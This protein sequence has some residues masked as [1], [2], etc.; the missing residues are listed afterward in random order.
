MTRFIELAKLALGG[1]RRAP[2]RTSLTVFGVAVSTGA[3]VTMVGYAFGMQRRFEAVFDALDLAKRIGVSPRQLSLIEAKRGDAH[4]EARPPLLDDEAVR[5]IST[6]RGVDRVYPQF[7]MHVEVSHGDVDTSVFALGMPNGSPGTALL[8]R[9]IVAGD[10]FA[11]EGPPGGL[12]SSSV[13]PEL[14]ISDPAAAIGATVTIHHAGMVEQKPGT[15]ALKDE[16]IELRV[17]GVFQPP[18]FGFDNLGAI[19]VPLHVLQSL[20]GQ[21][22]DYAAALTGGRTVTRG[23][24]SEVSVYVKSWSDVAP[25]EA[26][27]QGMGFETHAMAEVVDWYRRD[28]LLSK[29]ALTAVG[30]VAIIVAVLGTINTL[31][32]SVLERLEEI[33]LFKA[34]GASDGDVR[35]LFLIEAAWIGIVG[36]ISG[37][38]LGLAVAGL[39]Q[40]SLNDYAAE[41]GYPSE[42]F[43]FHFPPWFVAAAF[44]FALLSSIT[45][46][47]YPAWRAAR[48]DP[49]RSLRAG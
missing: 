39:L 21:R 17:T 13:L 49:V 44:S 48:V 16:E 37:V 47:V 25:V 7:G 34:L 20:P 36:G 33:G 3:L 1:L 24:Y 43:V 35:W 46:G 41:L 27:L 22:I 40:Y 2:L 23:S 38:L 14:D 31:L 6:I 18:P 15:F 5:A 32:M 42:F 28:F 29:F 11:T 19:V 4:G 9:F 10:V 30:S 12:L 45:G 8:R 26:H